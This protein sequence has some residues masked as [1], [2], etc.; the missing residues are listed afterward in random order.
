MTYSAGVDHLIMQEMRMPVLEELM[1]VDWNA[2][3]WL[4]FSDRCFLGLVVMKCL[5]MMLLPC[6]IHSLDQKV[7]VRLVPVG[8]LMSPNLYRQVALPW[9]FPLL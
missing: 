1:Y 2:V 3:D 6:T 5:T 8:I 7:M 4:V 9:L